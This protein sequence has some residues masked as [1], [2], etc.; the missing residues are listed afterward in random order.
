MSASGCP[1]GIP[2]DSAQQQA[3][4][5]HDFPTPFTAHYYNRA[6]NLALV[7][8]WYSQVAHK[9]ASFLFFYSAPKG[10]CCLPHGKSRTTV[11]G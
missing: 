3:G 5:S 6:V 4:P 8:R 1:P 2:C 10:A 11:P 7:M 9:A